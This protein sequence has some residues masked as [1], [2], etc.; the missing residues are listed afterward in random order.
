[1]LYYCGKP[2]CQGHELFSQACAEVK[3][4]GPPARPAPYKPPRQLYDYFDLPATRKT[5]AKNGRP[6]LTR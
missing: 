2:G 3:Q 4:E 5:A 1:M 6:A